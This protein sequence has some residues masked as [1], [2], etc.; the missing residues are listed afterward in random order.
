MMTDPELEQNRLDWIGSDL[1]T[2]PKSEVIYFPGC[3]P[4]Y[5]TVFGNLDVEGTEIARAAL[6]ILNHLGIEPMVL[7]N[8][9]CCG[10]DPYWQGDMET[11]RR[12]AELNLE[13]FLKSGAKRIITTCPECAYTLKTTYPEQVGDHG[14]EVLHITE[15]LVNDGYIKELFQ[16]N[17]SDGYPV[18]YQD[19]CRLGRFMGVYQ[20]PRDLIRGLGYELVD[21]G[22]S[23]RTS[24]CCGTSCWTNC[25]QLNKKIQSDRLLEARSTGAE[26]LITSCVKCQIH[27][28]CAQG[29]PV[30]GTEIQLDIQD[31]TTLIAERI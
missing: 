16:K 24:I 2:A 31:L 10:H 27:Y 14:L 11:F 9:R 15:F 30:L 18:T 25:G 17:D 4:Y 8:E 28:R 13:T 7:E 21:M 26:K 23:A 12:L 6:K 29:D 22:H 3:L 5:D 1:K 20:Q 19:P